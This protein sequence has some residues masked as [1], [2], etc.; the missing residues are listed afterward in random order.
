MR[1]GYQT[2]SN[3][4]V[5]HMTYRVQRFESAIEDSFAVLDFK[6]NKPAVPPLTTEQVTSVIYLVDEE[7]VRH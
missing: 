1:S 3:L 6:G 7:P 2:V 4:E 5:T